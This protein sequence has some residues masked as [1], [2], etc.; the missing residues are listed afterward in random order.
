MEIEQN[1]LKEES[2]TKTF[3][4]LYYD[5]ID[6]KHSEILQKLAVPCYSTHEKFTDDTRIQKIRELLQDSDY[7]EIFVDTASIWI[8]G[9]I[10]SDKPYYVISSHCD[11]VPQITKPFSVL[12]NNGYYKGTYD[13]IGTNAAAVITMLEGNFPDNV[14]FSFTADEETGHC[15][16]AEETVNFINSL[17]IKDCTYIALD[18]TAEGY[19]KGHLATL[20]NTPKQNP[21]FLHSITEA[22]LATE[23]EQTI[24]FV[25]KSKK[26]IPDNLPIHYISSDTGWYDEAFKYHELGITKTCSIC[27]PSYGEM[28]SNS[29]LKVRQPC[30]EGYINTLEGMIYSLTKTHEDLIINK[31]IE[32]ETLFKRSKELLEKE[33]EENRK[34]IQSYHATFSSDNF[35]APYTSYSNY[36]EDYDDEEDYDLDDVYTDLDLFGISDLANQYDED[37][38]E[39][40]IEDAM[41]I[42]NP[43]LLEEY[44]TLRERIIQCFQEQHSLEENNQIQEQSVLEN[45]SDVFGVDYDDY[46]DFN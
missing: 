32:K 34:K 39:Y 37:E 15:S 2:E 38:L 12:D 43:D 29:G 45:T 18:V 8:K 31:K 44:K 26:A 35:L 1:I 28:H 22:M 10:N 17:N 13:N 41:N 3:A 14:I 40:F 42:V 23:P 16:G 11:L 7:Q 24:T 4:E 6:L 5:D 30:F 36:Y 25:R 46:D 27:L 19:D 33:I 21:E 20:E 9:E